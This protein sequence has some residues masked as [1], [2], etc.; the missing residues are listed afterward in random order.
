VALRAGV[1]L[2]LLTPDRAAQRRLEAGLRQAALRGLL[3]ARQTGASR[4]RILHV[5]RWLASF[6]QPALG[7]VRSEAHRG[8]A[9]RTA[10]AA[11][12]LVRD[13]AGLL[14]LRPAPGD[15]IVVIT[16]QPRDL[17]PADSSADEPLALAE[18]VRRYHA[19]VIEVRVDA[20]PGDAQIAAAREAAAGA[21]CVVMATLAAD[22]QASQVRLVEAILSTGTPTATVAMRTPYDL[23]CYPGALTHLCSYAI[24]PASVGAVADALFGRQPIRGRLPVAIPGLYPRSHGMEVTRW[25]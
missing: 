19:E 15:R 9:R 17:T 24:V 3:S 21:R 11:I 20:E 18:A 7:V 2:L 4:A 5:R 23:A 10:S 22:V 14:P 12:T 13:E 16:P 25:A 6:D 8:L 1:D